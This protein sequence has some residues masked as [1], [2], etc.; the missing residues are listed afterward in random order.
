MNRLAVLLVTMLF[1]GTSSLLSQNLLREGNWE[2]IDYRAKGKWKII[3]KS[4]GFYVQLTDDFKTSS[5]PDLH[6]LFSKHKVSELTNSNTSPSS[7]IIAVL[8]SNKGAQE[9][10]IPE[11]IDWQNYRSIVIHCVAYSHLWAGA[12][13]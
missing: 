12:N 10:K 3:Q 2:K 5:G 9:F 1:L 6:I 8:K 7:V 13:F 4:D 11:N